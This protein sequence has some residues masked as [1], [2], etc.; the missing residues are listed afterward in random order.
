MELGESKAARRRRWGFSHPSPSITSLFIRF[1]DLSPKRLGMAR[2]ERLAVALVQPMAWC[3][4]LLRPVVWLY[5]RAAHVLFRVLGLSSLRD[6]RITSDDI[7]ATM[8]AGALPGVLA[9]REQQV[10]TNDF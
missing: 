2:P 4:T 6:D 10:I 8:E 1:S 5:S 3:I 7:L 9:A